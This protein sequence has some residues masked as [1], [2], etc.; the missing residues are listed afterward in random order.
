MGTRSA[1]E[2]A[3]SFANVGQAS[4]P[5]LIFQKRKIE[6]GD[7]QDACPTAKVEWYAG[8]ERFG[9][10]STKFLTEANKENEVMKSYQHTQPAT[11]I[12]ISVGAM[13][14][15]FAIGSIF[16]HTLMFTTVLLVVSM[17]I[18]RSLTIEISDTELKWYF[19]SGFLKKSVALDEV[20]SAEAIRT[21]FLNGWGIHYT[22]RGWLYNVSGYG[23]VAIT[24][25]SGKRFCLGTDE[26][27]KLARELMGRP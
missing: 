4:R 22:P 1:P 14:V 10:A 9:H 7:R 21:T 2:T 27:E 13:C 8:V 12:L 23:A 16:V 24:L 19:G 15:G 25:K 18:F 6:Y 20:V 11:T 3:R 26:P 17:W 5:S